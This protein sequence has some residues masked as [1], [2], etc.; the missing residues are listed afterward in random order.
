MYSDLSF[1]LL[2]FSSISLL[3]D[4]IFFTIFLM[5]RSFISFSNLFA[6]CTVLFF[7]YGFYVF[8]YLFNDFSNILCPFR[9]FYFMCVYSQLSD[10]HTALFYGGFFV[11]FVIFFFSMNLSLGEFWVVYVCL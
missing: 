10:L 8:F 4:L 5:S 1:S 7:Y 9:L 6:G 3:W 11:Q 2:I